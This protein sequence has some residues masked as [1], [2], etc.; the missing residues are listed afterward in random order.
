MTEQQR[1]ILDISIISV[2]GVVLLWVFYSLF[3][4]Q[5]IV[6]LA[7]NNSENFQNYLLNLG[8]WSEVAFVG[9]VVLEVLFAF[10]PGYV[11]YPVGAAIFGFEKTVLLILFGNLLGASVSFWIGQRWGQPLIRKFISAK[12]I[13]KFEDYMQRHGSLSIFFLKL[14]P[15]TSLDI[16]NYLA[17]TSSMPFWKFTIANMVGITPLVIISA[18]LGQEAFIIAPQILGV[19]VLLTF[20]YVIWFLLNLPRKIARSRAK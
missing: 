14:N 8:V 10:I 6:D 18:M 2:L 7:V 20:V 16:W 13:K 4:G 5:V 17:G 12:H 3:Q 11:I 15:L 9:S 1:R 19:L